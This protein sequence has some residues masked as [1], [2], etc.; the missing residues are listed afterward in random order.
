M[1]T[2]RLIAIIVVWLA[3]LF[4]SGCATVTRGTKDTLVVESDPAGAN[5]SLSTGH[6]G[7]TPTSFKLSRKDTVLVTIS[8]EGYETAVVTVNSQVV[9]AGAA[10]MAGNVLVGGLIGVGV[11]A[12]SGATK[13]LKP[14]PVTVKL[15][16][17][18]DIGV[19][20]AAK[21]VPK[22]L[23]SPPESLA[24]NK[25]EESEGATEEPEDEPPVS[26]DA[27]AP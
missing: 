24:A 10:G 22:K 26:P 4:L 7:K 11:D 20:Q 13:S 23:T 25:P 12:W 19:E 17:L 2:Q 15:V 5:V 14:N 3:A 21:T 18:E 6:S 27:A 16:K 1:K 8:R 9:G